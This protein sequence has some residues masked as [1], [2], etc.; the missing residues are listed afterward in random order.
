MSKADSQKLR[1]LASELHHAADYLDTT[2][3][4]AGYDWSKLEHELNDVTE[5]VIDVTTEHE[6][7]EE[8]GDE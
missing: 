2:G 6:P 3:S 7:P 1:D 4:P 5:I 8:A